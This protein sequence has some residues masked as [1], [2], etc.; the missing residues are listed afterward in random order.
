M[1]ESEVLE[2]IALYG[3][4]SITAFTVYIS[5]TFAFLATAFYVGHKLTTFQTL[6]ACG[7]FIFSAGSS[8]LAETAYIQAMFA[9]KNEAPNVLDGML[10]FSGNFWVPY[11]FALGTGGIIVSLYFMWDIRRQHLKS[12]DK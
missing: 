5:F 9:I 2:L 8:V 6:A 3:G 1:T 4:N 10:L 7:L 11:M 12:V